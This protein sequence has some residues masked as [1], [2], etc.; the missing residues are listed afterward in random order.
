MF[1]RPSFLADIVM[2]SASAAIS[3][4]MSGIERSPWPGSRS[5]MNQAFSAKRQAS[6][7]S[8]TPWRSQTARTARRFS[9]ET[10]CPPPELLVTVTNT[11]GTSR[12]ALGEQP[13]ERVDVHVALER[14]ERR[15]VAALGDDEVDRL[16]AGRLDVRPGRVEVGVVGHDLAGPAEDAE[17][18]LLGG[19]A[20]VGRDH[21]PEREELLDALQEREPRGRAGVAL[22]A[23]LDRGPLVA[24]TSRRCQNRS[25]GRSGRRRRGG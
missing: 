9:S 16:G 4:T 17:Q 22:V 24:A 25:A 14:V 19:A 23:V 10:G 13:V 15:R 1:A 8:G 7:K 5:L 18:D 21:V 12:G 3:R 11:T 20:L 6:R 2:P